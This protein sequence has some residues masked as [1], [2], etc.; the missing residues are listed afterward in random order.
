MFHNTES[1]KALNS[2]LAKGKLLLQYFQ[3][4]EDIANT[5]GSG[6]VAGFKPEDT[7]GPRT[8]LFSRRNKRNN[9]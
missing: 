6:Q 5:S 2:R 3:N 7:P 9:I 4:N 8:I 1:N